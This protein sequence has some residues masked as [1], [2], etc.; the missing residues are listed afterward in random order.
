MAI[1]DNTTKLTQLL[2][3]INN[4]PDEGSTDSG[5]GIVDVRIEEVTNN[6]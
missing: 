1:A 6:G 3:L 4:L 2:D 5:R